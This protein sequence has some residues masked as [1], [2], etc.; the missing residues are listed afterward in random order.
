MSRNMVAVDSLSTCYWLI[1]FID[2]M[3]N[4]LLL[5]REGKG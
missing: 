1:Y 5:L 2:E 3:A 4:S